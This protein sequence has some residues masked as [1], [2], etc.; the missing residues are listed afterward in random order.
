M[1]EQTCE[2]ELN[3]SGFMNALSPRPYLEKP[4]MIQGLNLGPLVTVLVS[5]QLFRSFISVF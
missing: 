2:V 4:M 3:S 1:R 5:A